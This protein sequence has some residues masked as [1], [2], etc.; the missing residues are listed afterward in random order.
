MIERLES[1]FS[2]HQD[3]LNTSCTYLSKVSY[4][5]TNFYLSISIPLS[6]FFYSLSLDGDKRKS[7]TGV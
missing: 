2:S 7:K 5:L 4:L 6:L 1:L 3:L